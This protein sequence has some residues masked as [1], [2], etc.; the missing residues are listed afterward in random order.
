[1]RTVAVYNFC[2]REPHPQRNNANRCGFFVFA[3]RT[4][5]DLL[6]RKTKFVPA[7]LECQTGRNEKSMA[8]LVNAAVLRNTAARAARSTVGWARGLSSH[9]A[10]GLGFNLS[11]DQ[12]AFQTAARDFAKDVI[13]PQ[14][15]AEYT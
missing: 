14:V 15:C 7:S 6:L 1:M 11:D 3:N 12:K 5:K 2:F 13:I 10:N 4:L 9:H 8:A